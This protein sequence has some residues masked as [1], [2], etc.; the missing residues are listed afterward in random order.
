MMEIYFYLIWFVCFDNGNVVH[1]VDDARRI[2]DMTNL[3]KAIDDKK[4]R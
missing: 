2:L 3:E 1:F 4:A